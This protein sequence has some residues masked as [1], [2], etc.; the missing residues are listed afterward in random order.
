MSVLIW[1]KTVCKSYQQMTKSSHSHECVNHE[2]SITM[3]SSILI[4]AS[5]LV[6]QLHGTNKGPYIAYRL[7]FQN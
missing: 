4:N 3:D 7:G 5:N 6:D 2:N 1:V